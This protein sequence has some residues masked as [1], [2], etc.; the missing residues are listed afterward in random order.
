MKSYFV[1]QI[2]IEDTQGFQEY[3]DGLNKIFDKYSG[4]YLAVDTDPEVLEGTWVYSRI[5]MIEFPDEK[6]LKRWYDSEEYQ[7]L[8]RL[9]NKAAQCDIL[10][11]KG[12]N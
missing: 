7:T 8:V 11:V 6:E 1:A 9:R 2:K 10:V 4:T 5:V 3:V 12:L